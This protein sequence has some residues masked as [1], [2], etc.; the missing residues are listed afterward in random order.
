MF[1]CS[2]EKTQDGDSAYVILH[3]EGRKAVC[4]N[5]RGA[6]EGGRVVQV[7]LGRLLQT[8]MARKTSITRKA[9]TARKIR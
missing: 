5:Q 7:G 1:D 2:T 8:R 9:R 4:K 6:G 3:D